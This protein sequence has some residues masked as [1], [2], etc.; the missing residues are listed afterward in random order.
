MLFAIAMPAY[1]V[2][3]S[4]Y[5]GQL[6]HAKQTRGITEAVAIYVCVA[7]LGLFVGVNWGAFTGIYTAITVFSIG[8][9]TQTLWLARRT[10]SVNRGLA[11]VDQLRQQ[12]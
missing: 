1:Q 8:G 10:R 12:T 11:Q 3:Q 5:Q 9:I 6:V 4:Y 2:F 7:L